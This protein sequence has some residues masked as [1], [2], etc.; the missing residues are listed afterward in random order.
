MYQRSQTSP[1]NFE[2]FLGQR[3]PDFYWRG[4]T[5][6]THHILK[7][8][9]LS[10]YNWKKRTKLHFVK[11]WA[12][13]CRPA[14]W[15]IVITDCCVSFVIIG[16]KWS[17]FIERCK[18]SHTV[19]QATK[20]SHQ[21]INIDSHYQQCA[22]IMAICVQGEKRETWSQNV[23]ILVVVPVRLDML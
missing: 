19:W 9:A 18:S 6:F 1:L 8:V 13:T 23:I 20:I 11:L 16:R 12:T 7:L 3:L 10:L 5:P 21:T 4:A 17:N 22:K 14:W 15:G 2:T